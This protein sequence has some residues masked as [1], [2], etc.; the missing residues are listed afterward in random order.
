MKT[1]NIG[2]T[3]RIL[4]QLTSTNYGQDLRDMFCQ[5]DEEWRGANG[6]RPLAKPILLITGRSR[7]ISETRSTGLIKTRI[8]FDLI[9]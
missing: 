3:S 9:T 6:I 5:E 1:H 8:L 2:R 7:T 4:Q